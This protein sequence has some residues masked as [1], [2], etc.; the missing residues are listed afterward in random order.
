V[1]DRGPIRS[2][3]DQDS[4]A[5]TALVTRPASDRRGGDLPQW[6]LASPVSFETLIWPQ[7]LT[8][9]V[10]PDPEDSLL[11]FNLQIYRHNHYENG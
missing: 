6:I 1:H 11:R 3:V 2:C 5:F 10:P 8:E 4:R 7:V 9:N